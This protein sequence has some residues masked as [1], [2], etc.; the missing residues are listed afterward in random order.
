[1]GSLLTACTGLLLR[2]AY[3]AAIMVATDAN[4]DIKPRDLG[5]ACPLNQVHCTWI[6]PSRA[7][8][9]AGLRVGR[10]EQPGTPE[11]RIS[12]EPCSTA[13]LPVHQA[14]AKQICI[15]SPCCLKLTKYVLCLSLAATSS[16]GPQSSRWP[17]ACLE[18][19]SA[20]L[21]SHC[22]TGSGC[23]QSEVEQS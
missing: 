23:P 10:A 9:M 18:R 7:S 2:E 20:W 15:S 11:Q 3:D 22:Q 5:P 17:P 19:A 14:P 13:F 12:G 4:S 16:L 21:K 6:V 1:M 8:S